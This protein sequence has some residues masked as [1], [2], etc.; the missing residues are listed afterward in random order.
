MSIFPPTTNRTVLIL[1]VVGCL[2]LAYLFLRSLW[3]YFQGDMVSTPWAPLFFGVLTTGL[4]RL[5]EWSRRVL[6]LCVVIMV[7][8]VP[9][10]FMNPLHPSKFQDPGSNLEFIYQVFVPSLAAL[11]YVYALG[12]YRDQFRR[13]YW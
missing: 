11:L 4:W 10:S 12:R 2:G 1:V 9:I 5:T 13:K 3:T 6:T 7:I 8:L